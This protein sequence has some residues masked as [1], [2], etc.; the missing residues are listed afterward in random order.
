MEKKKLAIIT[1]GCQ[2][3][4][5]DSEWLAGTLTEEYE[6][7]EDKT[8]A[9]FLVVNTC[10]VRDKAEHKFFSLLGTLRPLKAANKNLVIGVA[11]CMAQ[12]HGEMIVQREPLVDI[13]FGTRALDKAHILL[14]KFEETGRPQVDTSYGSEYEDFPVRRESALSAW[15]PIM[16]G[17]GNHCSYCIVPSTRGP[18]QS[19]PISN[20]LNEVSALIA[21]GYREITLL[22][23][24][25]NS[26]GV[27]LGGG[28]DF[29]GLLRQMNPIAVDARIRFVTSHPKD[30]SDSL[31]GAMT[32]LE[33]VCPYLHLPIQSGSDKILELM[34][35][36]YTADRYFDR[37][38]K[39]RER[40]P[41][42][43]LTSDVIVG[44]PGESDED[45]EAT[46]RAVERANYDN[47]FLFKYSPRPNTP[48]ENLPG[49][50]PAKLAQERFDRVMTLQKE[51]TAKRLAGWIGRDV[52]VLV[53]GPSKR[54]TEKMCGR[55]PQN[56][57]V[58]FT[59]GEDFTG[60]L[61]RVKITKSGQFSLHGDILR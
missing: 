45:F 48:A 1:L 40:I 15:V 52:E 44:F 57:V 13:V 18:E 35:R 6:Y 19:R 24:N 7:T 4:K 61:V 55:T 43:S 26:Y 50:I 8:E 37:V 34:K 17:C 3:N 54:D 23:Q 27:G 14:R 2:M 33:S 20:L 16:R 28:V 49:R 41:D 46:F 56:I 11:G 36:G 53:D 60:R 51:I 22:G 10:A 47:I 12:E 58:N 39:L 30:L 25:V 31:I 42:L 29:P 32:E 21:Q 59:S 9:D 5:S 38:D